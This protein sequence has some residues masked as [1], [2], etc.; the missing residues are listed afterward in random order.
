MFYS[1]LYT[2]YFLSSSIRSD[3]LD[4]KKYGAYFDYCFSNELNTFSQQQVVEAVKSVRFLIEK[5]GYK[6]YDKYKDGNGVGGK[7]FGMI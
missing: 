2:Q 7:K 5:L 4:E 1:V 3:I 6:V